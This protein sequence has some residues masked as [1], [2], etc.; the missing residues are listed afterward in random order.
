MSKEKYTKY[1]VKD[2]SLAEWGRREIN[3]AEAEMPLSLI[4][5]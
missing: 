1:K 2:L 4:H 3:I 5:I